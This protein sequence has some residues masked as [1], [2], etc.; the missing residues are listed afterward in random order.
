MGCLAR[1]E[2][3]RLRLQ[4]IVDLQS[5]RRLGFVNLY[6]V[7]GQRASGVTATAA[8]GGGLTGGGSKG[9]VPG[10]AFLA[11][12]GPDRTFCSLPKTPSLMKHFVPQVNDAATDEAWAHMSKCHIPFY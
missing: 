4:R 2:E 3:L 8:G 5:Q 11:V 10:S 1:G 7:L 9:G 12:T 6:T